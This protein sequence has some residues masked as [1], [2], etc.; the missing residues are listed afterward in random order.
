[1]RYVKVGCGFKKEYLD[2]CS[3]VPLI[4]EQGW[5]ESEINA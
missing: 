1:M 5:K 4:G 3:F 2:D